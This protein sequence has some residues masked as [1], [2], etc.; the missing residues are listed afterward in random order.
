MHRGNLYIYG[1]SICRMLGS[2]GLGLGLKF[3]ELFFLFCFGNCL[4]EAPSDDIWGF[5]EPE[6]T[7]EFLPL[8]CISCVTMSE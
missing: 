4:P 7:V 8:P 2:P 5:Q 3:R 1:M 6:T